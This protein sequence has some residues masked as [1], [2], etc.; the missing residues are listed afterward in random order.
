M[1]CSLFE[2]TLL[3]VVR[4]YD[5]LGVLC[6]STYLVLDVHIYSEAITLT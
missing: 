6:L 1:K 2:K 3:E 4:G 5:Q